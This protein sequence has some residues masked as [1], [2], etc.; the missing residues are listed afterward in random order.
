MNRP[1]ERYLLAAN[2]TSSLSPGSGGFFLYSHEFLQETPGDILIPDDDHVLIISGIC[3]A[4]RIKATCHNSRVI[5]DKHLVVHQTR[6][7]I[8]QN[9]KAKSSEPPVLAVPLPCL[10]GI[11]NPPY[12]LCV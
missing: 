6:I 8:E 5:D 1:I 11:K 2:P 7:F 4:G 10:K 9:I 12:I 3:G